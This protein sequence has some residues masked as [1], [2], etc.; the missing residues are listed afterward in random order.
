VCKSHG[1]FITF[2][3]GTYDEGRC[4]QKRGV[5]EI[6]E[7]RVRTK[8]ILAAMAA[9]L[10][11]RDVASHTTDSR[12]EELIREIADNPTINPAT[13]QVTQ[14][15]SS[16]LMRLSLKQDLVQVQ[17]LHILSRLRMS[18]GDVNHDLPLYKQPATSTIDP[19]N[20]LIE[21]YSMHI[22]NS[23]QKSGWDVLKKY[24]GIWDPAKKQ[25]TR[26]TDAIQII[27]GLIKAKK[28]GKELHRNIMNGRDWRALFATAFELWS[29]MNGGTPMMTWTAVRLKKSLEYMSW[30][31]NT[32][33]DMTDLHIALMDCSAQILDITLDVLDPKHKARHEAKDHYHVAIHH[34]AERMTATRVPF[35]ISEEG[36]FEA[37][38]KILEKLWLA[39]VA[40][41][42]AKTDLKKII[43]LSEIYNEGA[44]RYWLTKRNDKDA[45]APA[46]ISSFLF[47]PCCFT[48]NKQRRTMISRCRSTIAFFGQEKY[49]SWA[50]RKSTDG[51]FVR[52]QH[53]ECDTKLTAVCVCTGSI[54]TPFLRCEWLPH[55]TVD[56]VV[57]SLQFN[58]MRTFVDNIGRCGESKEAMA[59]ARRSKE[60]KAASQAIRNRRIIRELQLEMDQKKKARKVA[61][62][63]KN[64]E[65]RPI[66]QR[67][68]RLDDDTD[69]LLS[70]YKPTE[71]TDTVIQQAE[72]LLRDFTM[73]GVA[74]HTKCLHN[75]G[76]SE[77]N[78][79]AMTADTQCERL[80]KFLTE[81]GPSTTIEHTDEIGDQKVDDT[82][83]SL[84]QIPYDIQHDIPR[85]MPE[86]DPDNID[87]DMKSPSSLHSH[88]SCSP[89]P[90]LL[91]SKMG[92]SPPSLSFL[93]QAA[94]ITN[95]SDAQALIFTTPQTSKS[96]PRTQVL[97]SPT[98]R[99][100]RTRKRRPGKQLLPT[101]VATP[102]PSDEESDEYV[103]PTPQQDMTHSS[104]SEE[105]ISIPAP[106]RRRERKQSSRGKKSN[107][108]RSKRHPRLPR[109]TTTASRKSRQQHQRATGQERKKNVAKM[110]QQARK[111]KL[112]HAMNNIAY[113]LAGEVYVHLPASCT[114]MS[115]PE[116]IK[117]RMWNKAV[118][119]F[120]ATKRMELKE[121]YNAH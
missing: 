84:L 96:K 102:I 2:I 44:I 117:T 3:T 118:D 97:D 46:V 106:M 4:G 27:I 29:Y 67:C 120:F 20:W 115:Y 36:V 112:D 6:Q 9:Y 30:L 61:R 83:S 114:D 53:Q 22:I 105:V 13:G 81:S 113:P 89:T 103:P 18:L 109:N 34:F 80:D 5:K 68:D 98:R 65:M 56:A 87:T 100:R 92:V 70:K 78:R 7:A 101:R 17:Q 41:R 77:L 119:S 57:A 47:L 24:M 99:V 14:A 66:T 110:L 72:Q 23:L 39:S 59:S 90:L 58:S 75:R 21:V 60:K 8:D 73:V 33:D 79:I 107:L 10:K 26:I 32:S 63:E 55:Q 74:A 45:L 54:T 82:E 19:D 88:L 111:K 43:G 42:D 62:A 64:N 121:Q 71:A 52:M 86:E 40:M 49:W 31:A 25:M 116:L 48:T 51:M 85:D 108:R 104:D 38:L 95:V 28:Q 94:A 50:T 37:H 12:Y 69:V 93:E 76:C 1:S 16:L 35:L 11:R 15:S 91:D